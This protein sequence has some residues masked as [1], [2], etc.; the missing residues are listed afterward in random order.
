MRN[1][2]YIKDLGK[3]QL[4]LPKNMRKKGEKLPQ[5]TPCTLMKIVQ[6][7]SVVC[8]QDRYCNL[9]FSQFSGFLEVVCARKGP[10]VC[11]PRASRVIQT[12]HF[13]LS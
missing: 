4:S 3:R 2:K 11:V 12:S 10:C 9:F 5:R 8:S 7:H 1:Q 13:P 6:I